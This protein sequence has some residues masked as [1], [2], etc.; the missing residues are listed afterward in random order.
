MC[1]E[2]GN[3]PTDDTYCYFLYYWI[4]GNVMNM[5]KTRPDFRT[6]MNIIY[7]ELKT[8]RGSMCKCSTVHY[9]IYEDDF[10]YS[11]ELFDYSYNYDNMGKMSNGSSRLCEGKYRDYLKKITEAYRVIQEVCEEGDDPEC[12]KIE[13][14]Y[15][16]YFNGK[17]L[18][19]E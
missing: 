7:N 3:S 11:K 10:K 12:K 2:W 19:F 6:I 9:D 8:I 1:K 5:K 17:V 4:G 16:P 15:K 18:N 14:K 13:R